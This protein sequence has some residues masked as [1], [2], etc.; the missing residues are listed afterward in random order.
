MAVL[1]FQAALLFP[2]PPAVP[3]PQLTDHGLTAI[4]VSKD[5]SPFGT[6]HQARRPTYETL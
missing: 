6:I 1:F 2:S 3:P 4:K 5:G